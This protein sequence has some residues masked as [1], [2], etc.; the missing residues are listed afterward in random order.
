MTLGTY[1][2]ASE[3][4]DL[5]VRLW[6]LIPLS[7]AVRAVIRMF[8]ERLEHLRWVQYHKRMVRIG[9]TKDRMLDAAILAAD[10][11]DHFSTELL[12]DKIYQLRSEYGLLH[13]LRDN[14]LTNEDRLAWATEAEIEKE[15]RKRKRRKRKT[16]RAAKTG[17]Q[18]V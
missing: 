11:K 15:L 10:H 13:D 2:K 7:F 3:F 5:W 12:V 9:E 8:K 1:V 18:R 16:K 14:E 4:P 6:A 17:M